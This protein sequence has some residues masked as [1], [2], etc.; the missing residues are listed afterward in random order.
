VLLRS[1]KPFVP[2]PDSDEA[3]NKAEAE[4]SLFYEII[5]VLYRDD[6]T[7]GDCVRAALP[8]LH[9]N[10]TASSATDGLK[11]RAEDL[12][13]KVGKVFTEDG[14]FP[15]SDFERIT[16]E[17]EKKNGFVK[18][19]LKQALEDYRKKMAESV[20]K[21]TFEG[22]GDVSDD[23]DEH[24]RRQS[25]KEMKLARLPENLVPIFKKKVPTKA[26]ASD[27]KRLEWSN[28]IAFLNE[29]IRQMEDALDS[30]EGEAELDEKGDALPL[31]VEVDAESQNCSLVIQRCQERVADIESLL[32]LEREPDVANDA[33]DDSDDSSSDIDRDYT[34]SESSDSDSDSESE[35][36]DEE[37]PCDVQLPPVKK[38]KTIKMCSVHPAI[39]LNTGGACFLCVTDSIAARKKAREDA[40][41]AAG[42]AVPKCGVCKTELKGDLCQA[43]EDKKVRVAAL[44]LALDNARAAKAVK[45]PKK[46]AAAAPMWSCS[47]HK[48]DPACAECMA[49]IV[50][51]A[52]KVTVA[53]AA[54]SPS[55]SSSSTSAAAAT[56]SS[57]M[58][59]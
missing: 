23:D 31:S 42:P 4:L 40:E 27:S 54:A 56:S 22:K 20:A 47:V 7:L 50:K 51:H 52:A 48:P 9:L 26:V 59:D 24:E 2:K 37:E 28:E 46:V 8:M 43:C 3:E 38:V 36:D 49:H 29:Q 19:N 16:E 25:L 18:S 14:A 57:D 33:D 58:S 30:I 44:K 11:R 12:E 13:K 35:K 34:D 32:W 5:Q 53:A 17:I 6:K 55:S 45:P 39:E 21:G 10:L 1:K 41:K 15:Q